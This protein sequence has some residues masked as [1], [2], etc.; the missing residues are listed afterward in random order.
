MSALDT[1]FPMPE[2]LVGRLLRDSRG[3]SAE[4]LQDLETEALIP[5][6]LALTGGCG[7]VFGLAIGLPGGL[8]QAASSAIKFPIVL[9]GAAALTVPALALAA[10]LSGVRLRLPQLSALVLQA[11]STAAAVMAA[12]VPLAVVVWLSASAFSDSDW[13]VYRRA[14]AAFTVVAGVGGLVGALRLVRA[15]PFLAVGPWSIL[16]GLAG[17]QITWLLRPIIGQPQQPFSLLRPL[18][19][20]GLAEVLVMFSKVLL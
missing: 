16:F 7:A 20:N 4:I 12:L 8:A 2:P 18:E 6:L 10:S 1:P 9:M 15:L 14:V 19:S 11:L 5:R 17:L 3:L 13:Y